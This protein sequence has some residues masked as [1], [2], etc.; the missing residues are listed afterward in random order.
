MMK[1]VAQLPINLWLCGNTCSY[2][3]LLVKIKISVRVLVKSKLPPRVCGSR[4]STWA[5]IRWIIQPASSEN[6]VQLKTWLNKAMCGATS[7]ALSQRHL[8]QDRLTR[9]IS[10]CVPAARVLC[11]FAIGNKASGVC[12]LRF[13]HPRNTVLHER[14]AL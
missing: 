10:R 7:S 12:G 4:C 13:Q 2:E 6:T 9:L 11:C 8:R 14:N 3:Y 1:W 5:S